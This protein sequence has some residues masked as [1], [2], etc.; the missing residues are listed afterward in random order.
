MGLDVEADMVAKE[1]EEMVKKKKE[2]QVSIQNLFWLI[3]S[4]I[5]LL[6]TFG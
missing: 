6:E 3:L 4:I 1:N 5:L 2:K